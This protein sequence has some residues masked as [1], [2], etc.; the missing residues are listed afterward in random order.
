MSRGRTPVRSRQQCFAAVLRSNGTPAAHSAGQGTRW[1]QFT[2]ASHGDS[3]VSQGNH[4]RRRAAVGRRTGR[5]PRARHLGVRR[6]RQRRI[7]QRGRDAQPRLRRRWALWHLSRR[8]GRRRI[9]DGR[10]A[11][12]AHPRPQQRQRRP[13]VQ[14]SRLDA[15]GGG[16]A[17]HPAGS[18]R[19]HRHGDQLPAHVWRQRPVRGEVRPEQHRRD[20]RRCERR[21]DGELQ[22]EPVPEPA[23]RADLLP[24]PQPVHAG[25]RN[26]GRAGRN[27]VSRGHTHARTRRYGDPARGG[28]TASLRSKRPAHSPRPVR[29]RLHGAPAEVA[30]RP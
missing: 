5:V 14:P 13:P 9:R 28:C 2:Q 12:H 6:L 25:R 15:H 8:K 19:R 7:V 24:P 20:P 16:S 29:H 3:H 4:S 17:V 26:T 18:R 22:L 27:A 21:L 23:H 1:R 10:N 11:G 30:P